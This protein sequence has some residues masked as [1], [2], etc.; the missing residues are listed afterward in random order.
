MPIVDNK[1]INGTSYTLGCGLDGGTAIRYFLTKLLL[2]DTD[3]KMESV[4]M[5]GQ[6]S[7]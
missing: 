5:L 3:I 7:Q 6:Q 2:P 4:C 1:G